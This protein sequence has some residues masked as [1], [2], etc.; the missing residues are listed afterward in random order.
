[1]ENLPPYLNYNQIEVRIVY[2]L[3]LWA[4]KPQNQQNAAFF[5]SFLFVQTVPCVFGA[6]ERAGAAPFHQ[7]APYYQF[8]SL[9]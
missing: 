5:L 6:P 3:I 4:P 7:I 2:H 8:K 1:M 9:K